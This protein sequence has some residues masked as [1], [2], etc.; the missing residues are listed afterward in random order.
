MQFLTSLLLLAPAALAIPAPQDSGSGSGSDNACAEK[1]KDFTEWTLKDF[2]LLS[3]T[4]R[5]APIFAMRKAHSKV[6]FSVANEILG[7]DVD[8]EAE[9][10]A[11]SGAE[12]G[13][14]EFDGEVQFECA[15]PKDKEMGG[16]VIFSFDESSGKIVMK[17]KWTCFDDPQWP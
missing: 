13:S 14:G 1:V 11:G 6:T 3:N 17:Q 15:A 12:E 7:Y 2:T 16:D 9:A 4:T 10:E 8:C 5:S